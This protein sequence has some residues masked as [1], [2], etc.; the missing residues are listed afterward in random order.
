MKQI[1]DFDMVKAMVFLHG[2]E[3]SDELRREFQFARVS[4]GR[5]S[6]RIGQIIW[7]ISGNTITVLKDDGKVYTVVS[8]LPIVIG[9]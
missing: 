8:V 2:V 7:L 9:K 1:F 3:L 5:I 4:D 6:I